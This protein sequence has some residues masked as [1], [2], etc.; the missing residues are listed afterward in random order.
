M[1]TSLF[2]ERLLITNRVSVCQL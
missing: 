2:Y 1:K